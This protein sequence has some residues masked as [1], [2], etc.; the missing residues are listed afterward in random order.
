MGKPIKCLLRLHGVRRETISTTFD[1]ISE[2][3]RWLR[4]WYRPYTLVREDE[5]SYK[6]YVKRRG[7]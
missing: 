6:V 5:P 7:Y 4:C 2:A 1:S 3:R